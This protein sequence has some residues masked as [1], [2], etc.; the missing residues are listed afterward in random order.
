MIPQMNDGQFRIMISLATML[1]A[2]RFCEQNLMRRVHSLDCQ[3][4]RGMI[5]M[6][7]GSGSIQEISLARQ[8]RDNG[9]GKPSASIGQGEP[10][11]CHRN[12]C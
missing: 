7:E 8:A 4:P 11:T 12:A 3:E 6:P 10:V 5:A 2:A 9:P 1:A